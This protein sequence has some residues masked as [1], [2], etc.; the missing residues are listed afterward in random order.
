MKRFQRDH[1]QVQRLE[2]LR[3]INSMEILDQGLA[4]MS[5]PMVV[6]VETRLK[7]AQA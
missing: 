6:K 2:R 7:L 4:H 5:I 3:G 1:S